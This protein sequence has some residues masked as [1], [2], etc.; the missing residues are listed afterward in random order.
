MK[1]LNGTENPRVEGSIPFQATNLQKPVPAGSPRRHPVGLISA[2]LLLL[3]CA[4]QAQ[5]P[6]TGTESQPDATG[7]Y[8][9]T[10]DI[11]QYMPIWVS[12]SSYSEQHY[13]YNLPPNLTIRR[14]R[15]FYAV[16]RTHVFEGHL[17]VTANDFM[18]LTRGPHKESGLTNYDAWQVHDVAYTSGASGAYLDVFALCAPTG[19]RK[20]QYHVGLVVEVVPAATAQ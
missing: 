16:G 18:L 17:L 11:E 19:S 14:I 20:V 5:T 7:A 12:A 10:L 9:I 13:R 15:S 6:I 8:T 3:G 2:M 4:A 1:P